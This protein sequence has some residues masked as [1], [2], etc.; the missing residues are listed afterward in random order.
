LFPGKGDKED[1]EVVSPG[2]TP[3]GSEGVAGG[4]CHDAMDYSG[5]SSFSSERSER[6]DADT[7][8]RKMFMSS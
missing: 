7:L 8:R 5:A 1:S 6:S 3:V 2:E 4:A